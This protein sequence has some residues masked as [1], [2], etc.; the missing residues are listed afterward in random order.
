[1]KISL[2]YFLVLAGLAILI[3]PS[4][5]KTES[6]SSLL[7]KE[8]R[9]VN[10]FLSGQKI[11][12]DLPADSVLLYG[13]DAPFYK[14]NEDGTLYI[15][16]VTP[17]DMNP[18]SRPKAGEKVYFRFKRQNLEILQ[19]EGEAEWDGNADNIGNLS[20]SSFVFEN[21]YLPNTTQYGMGIQEPLKFV[22]YNSEVYI[23]IK[24]R[25]GVVSEQSACQPFLY[26]VKYFKAL[27]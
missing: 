7:K 14:M 20:S 23:V 1:M 10:W 8:E 21:T 2:K 3:L 6:Y 5:S 16:V 18:E 22:G 12:V 19:N 26:N 17:G 15:K 11:C 27:Y 13:E 24:S 25:E 4:C 9:A